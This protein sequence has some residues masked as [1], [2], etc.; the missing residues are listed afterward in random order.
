MDDYA[1]SLSG[2]RSY[3][4]QVRCNFFLSITLQ[5]FADPSSLQLMIFQGDTIRF[6]VDA[7]IRNGLKFIVDVCRQLEHRITWN[8]TSSG[9]T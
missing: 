1:F 5:I 6:R 9:V 8:T 2:P 7:Y 4:P 3:F